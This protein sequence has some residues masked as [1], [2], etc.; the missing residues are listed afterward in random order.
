MPVNNAQEVAKLR[1]R[2]EEL[3]TKMAF[4]FRRLGVS[5]PG[6]PPSARASDKVLDLAGRGDKA[7]AIKAFMQETGASLKDAMN[8]VESL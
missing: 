3:E 7:G 5:Q 4:L 6:D 2:V 1:Q 8:F